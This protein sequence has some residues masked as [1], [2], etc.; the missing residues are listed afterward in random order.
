MGPSRP[1]SA[2]AALVGAG[3]LLFLLLAGIAAWRI[4]ALRDLA[5]ERERARLQA[6]VDDQVAR[7]EEALL[8]ELWDF[9]GQVAESPGRAVEIQRKLRKTKDWFDSLFLWRPGGGDGM[10]FPLPSAPSAPLQ[11]Q[12]S[13]CLARAH[14]IER[15][16][17]ESLDA[18]VTEYVQGCRSEEPSIR[19]YAGKQAAHHLVGAARP[20]EALAVLDATAL[21]PPMP[22]REAAGALAVSPF[23]LATHRLASVE[24]RLALADGDGGAL[25]DAEALGRELA[26]LDAPDLSAAGVPMNQIRRLLDRAGRT[27]AAVALDERF[28]RAER[29]QEAYRQVLDRL[30]AEPP[31][32]DQKRGRI[33]LDP[34]SAH[35]FLLHYGWTEGPSD[36]GAPELLGVAFSLEERAL[37]SAFL[38]RLPRALAG[39]TYVTEPRTGRFLD[40][41]RTGGRPIVGAQFR[42]TL[43]HLRVNV[44][45]AALAGA[46]AES[47]EQWVVLLA[48]ITLSAALGVATIVSNE[49][50]ARQQVELLER[51]RAFGTRVTHELK[52]PLAGI[53][54]MAEN[55]EIGAFRDDRQRAEMAHRIVQEADRLS[56][57]VDE[58]LAAAKERTIPSPVAFDPEE[59]VLD[60]AEE[61]APRMQDA[62]I[63]FEVDPGPTDPL[64]GDPAALRDALACL[65][66]NALKYRR[67]QPASRVRFTMTQEG[68][69]VTFAVVDNGLGV[70]KPMRKRIFDRFVRVEGPHRGTAGG[71]GLGLSQVREIVQAHRG[72]VTCGD[73]LDGGS[74]F[75]I[76]IPVPRG[77]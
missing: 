67:E 29:R 46:A 71:H 3:V 45:Q 37:V 18:I 43:T 21:R 6:L 27:E 26:D 8:A 34:F 24:I 59:I 39:A 38:R 22:L 72:T 47:R 42:Q 25:A 15:A 74:A 63:A 64:R 35:P 32:A 19:L 56:R 77:A 57:R 36:A 44:R 23:E 1:L 61:W 66:D 14:H 65:L 40:G 12:T 70:P 17:P 28:E 31:P 16:H 41:A 73:G 76:R 7:F 9:T 75:T 30:L 60:L 53:K 10:L 51:Q 55:L 5:V 4:L 50:T 52:T 11:L 48:V 69:A 33:V 2:R 58:V 68:R 49:R 54:V 62:G 13:L 20:V